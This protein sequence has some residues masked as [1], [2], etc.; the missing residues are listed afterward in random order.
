[1]LSLTLSHVCSLTIPETGGLT[2]SPLYGGNTYMRPT[3]Q[4]SDK[5][6]PET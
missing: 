4:S 3:A 6:I 1:M 2:V 5:S